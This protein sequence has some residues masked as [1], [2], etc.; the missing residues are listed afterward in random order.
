MVM[1]SLGLDIPVCGMVK[2]DHHRTRGLYYKD[3]ELTFRKGSE[4]MHMITALQDET[5]RFAITYHKLLRSKEQTH[6]ILD[7]IPGIGPKRRRALLLNFETVEALKAATIEDLTALPEMN[8]R[9]AE[10]VY[11]FFHP[12]EQKPDTP[13][14]SEVTNATSPSEGEPATKESPT[15]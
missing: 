7:D 10:A 9:S 6:S 2:D 1:D 12:N 14:D 3:Q 8:Q 4:A 5:H 11:G 13:S 15:E